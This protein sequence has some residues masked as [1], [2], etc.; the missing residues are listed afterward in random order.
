M[1]LITLAVVGEASKVA[2][3][4]QELMAQGGAGNLLDPNSP[5]TGRY[6]RG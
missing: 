4:L 3:R 6:V 5:I 1:T 2:D